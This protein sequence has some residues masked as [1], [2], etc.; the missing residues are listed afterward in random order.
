MSDQGPRFRNREEAGRALAEVLQKFRDDRP[1]VLG[2]ARGGVAIARAVAQVLEAPLDVVVARRLSV[3]WEPD[4][5]LGAVAES[6][7]MEIDQ[8]TIAT[9]NV[10][11]GELEYTIARERFEIGRRVREWRSGRPLPELD[12]RTALLIDDGLAT[13]ATARAALAAVRR[14]N[15]S[16]MVFAAPVGQSSVLRQLTEF[17]DEVICPVRIEGSVALR[18]FYEAFPEVRD[19]DVLALLADAP[20]VGAAPASSVR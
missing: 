15:P 7:G 4:V 2:I 1:V 18:R 13:G 17:A 3:P 14:H 20:R 10:E 11:E 6:G 16:R 19:A 5:S 9:A 8:R 12:G